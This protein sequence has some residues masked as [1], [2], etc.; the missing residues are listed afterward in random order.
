MIKSLL[1]KYAS[2]NVWANK[3]LTDFILDLDEE[4]WYRQTP[5]SFDSL[6]KTVVHMWNAESIWWQRVQMQETIVEPRSFTKQMQDACMGLMNQSRQWQD[7]LK[8]DDLNENADTIL[9]YKNLKGEPFKQVT[10]EVLL[11]LFNHGTYHRGQLIT[12]LHA[13]G[14]HQ[15]PATDF[16]VWSRT[17][18]DVSKSV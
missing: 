6:F 15:L 10:S 3:T 1:E 17:V 5:S 8:S 9:N 11:H 16:I 12:M 4:L 13:L 7:Y 14:I 18:S 2:F